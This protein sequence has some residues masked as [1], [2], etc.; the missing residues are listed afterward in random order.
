MFR[1][2][3]GTPTAGGGLNTLKRRFKWIPCRGAQRVLFDFEKW[4]FQ[5][6]LVLGSVGR[7]GSQGQKQKA[8]LAHECAVLLAIGALVF[9][10]NEGYLEVQWELLQHLFCHEH[11][12][13]TCSALISTKHINIFLTALTGQS[14]PGRALARPKDKQNKMATLLR[15][16]TEN[17]RFVPV[18]GPHLFQGRVPFVPE[19]GP[20]CP[21]TVP[22]SCPIQNLVGISALKNPPPLPEDTLPTP[23]PV[24]PAPP[25]LLPESGQGF[26]IGQ[27]FSCT[28]FWEP[29]DVGLAPTGVWRV[30]PIPHCNWAQHLTLIDSFPGIR[31][32]VRGISRPTKFSLGRFSVR[33]VHSYPSKLAEL[34]DIFPIPE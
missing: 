14:S 16:S 18:M 29:P 25:P 21:D 13:C 11:M 1:P 10:I 3:L 28:K 26:R 12:E 24:C 32:D 30:P 2:P 15:N 9:T 31:P 4:S 17:G 27:K 7:G 19:T 8:K 5:V 33:E 34:N 6:F 20:V 23:T 22:L